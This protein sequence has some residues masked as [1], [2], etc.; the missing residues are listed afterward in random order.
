MAIPRLLR[1]FYHWLYHPFAWVY[2]FVAAV[3]SLGRWNEWIMTVM[4]LIEGTRVLELGHGPGHLQ[5]RLLD[6]GLFAV[7]LDESPQMSRLAARRLRRSGETRVNLTRALAQSLP[8]LEE[9]F[10]TVVSTFPSEYIFDARTLS[11]AKRVLHNGGRFIVLPVA[12]P[13]NRFLSWLYRVTGESPSDAVEVV[14]QKIS[15][16]V[17][18]AGFTV[19]T[20]VVEVKSSVL[21]VIVAEK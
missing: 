9:T 5:R 11:E 10:D 15:E 16:P 12:W 7:G 6:L 20:E 2:D 17:F 8:F 3:V 14:K 4:P 18:E 19:R 1:V 13:K 21:L